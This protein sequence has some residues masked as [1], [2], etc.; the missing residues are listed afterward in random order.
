LAGDP[1][2]LVRLIQIPFSHNCIKVRRALELKGLSFE[3]LDINPL[4]RRPVRQASGQGLVPVLVDG[5]RA[6]ADSTEILLY[7]ES[8]YP[9]P[10][11]L[12]REAEQRAECLLL[13]DWAD[14]AFMALT[15]RIAYWHALA[16]P[17][18]IESLF[19]PEARGVSRRVRGALA[20]RLLRRRFGLSRGRSRRDETEALRLARLA[21]ERLGG[22]GY[23]VGD[24]VTLADVALAAMSLPLRLAAPA[25]RGDPHVRTLL[26][27]GKRI[28]GEGGRTS[29]SAEGP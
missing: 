6:I 22:R 9:E 18:A 29:V 12:P 2:A 7:L 5:E 24:S 17:D 1:E 20:R 25:V 23:L 27:W 15:R 21:A 3:T 8:A 4:D 16:R 14:S 13:E 19:C 28:L 11:L 10:P 26:A